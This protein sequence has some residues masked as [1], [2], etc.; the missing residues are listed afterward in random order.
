MS[1]PEKSKQR[2]KWRYVY[3]KIGIIK[4]LDLEDIKQTSQSSMV[5]VKEPTYEEALLRQLHLILGIWSLLKVF[6]DLY[7]L[8]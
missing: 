8:L 7:C 6:T 4:T 5:E 3:R 2:E 1:R